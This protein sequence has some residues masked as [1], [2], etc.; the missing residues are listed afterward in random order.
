MAT[1]LPEPKPK[2]TEAE[3]KRMQKR[4]QK[5]HEVQIVYVK[6]EEKAQ[7]YAEGQHL[8]VYNYPPADLREEDR[9]VFI[10]FPPGKLELT[11]NYGSNFT[12]EGQQTPPIMGQE[13]QIVRRVEGMTDD[14]RKAFTAQATTGKHGWTSD[15]PQKLKRFQQVLGNAFPFLCKLT[16][17]EYSGGGLKAN[18]EIYTGGFPHKPPVP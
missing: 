10:P 11:F 5:L 14:E 15:A 4:M 6:D 7:E 12:A 3:Q 18:P 1:T 2:T 13:P 17:A 16:V 8:E 9:I